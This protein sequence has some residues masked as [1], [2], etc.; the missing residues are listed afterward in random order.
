MHFLANTQKQRSC[1]FASMAA[2]LAFWFA[3]SGFSVSFLDAVLMQTRV[4]SAAYDELYA[5]AK[6]AYGLEKWTE[7][8]ELFEK[9][10]ADYKHEKSVKIFCRSRCRDRYRAF[11][12]SNL[13][14]DLELDYYRYTIYSHKCSQQCREK[15]L[16]RRTKVSALVREDFESRKTYGYLQFAYYKVGEFNSARERSVLTG[17][18]M[19]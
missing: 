4:K 18:T 17:L 16:G 14:N 9:A 15:Y 2:W 10:I 6:H 12:S 11:S 13:S 1:P 8:A 3:F 5:D 7:A 19:I